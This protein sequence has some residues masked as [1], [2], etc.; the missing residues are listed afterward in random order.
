MTCS[1]K[2]RRRRKYCPRCRDDFYNGKNPIGVKE[3]WCLPNSRVVR[4]KF[5]HV[6]AVP[7]LRMKSEW[8]L[9]CCHRDRYISVDPKVTR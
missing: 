3:C 7:P 2:N 4:R 5:V 8:T 6:D 9:D 1:E